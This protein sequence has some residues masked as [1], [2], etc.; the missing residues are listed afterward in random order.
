MEG[1]MV[2]YQKFMNLS[3]DSEW[4]SKLLAISGG[5]PAISSKLS[6]QLQ[7]PMRFWTRQCRL[8]L[9]SG[10][11]S[12]TVRWLWVKVLDEYIGWFQLCYIFLNN[13]IMYNMYFYI[14]IYI[15]ICSDIEQNL[16]NDKPVWISRFQVRQTLL[17]IVHFNFIHLSQ[18][19]HIPLSSCSWSLIYGN[20]TMWRTWISSHFSFLG[21]L[22]LILWMVDRSSLNFKWFKPFLGWF[23]EMTHIFWD[24]LKHV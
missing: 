15:Y 8:E 11:T 16:Q 9:C 19:R 23:V 6:Q 3:M 1:A 12:V 5:F 24:W 10:M 20:M 21:W 7:V 2:S 22:G 14:Y 18:R 4:W 13:Y 17:V